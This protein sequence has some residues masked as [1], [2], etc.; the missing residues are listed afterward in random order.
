ME[1][2]HFDP[3]FKSTVDPHRSYENAINNLGIEI[4]EDVPESSG[5]NETLLNNEISLAMSSAEH[6]Q[7][8]QEIESLLL[9]PEAA[10]I[11]PPAHVKT[12]AS[13]ASDTSSTKNREIEDI[14]AKLEIQR[15]EASCS[16]LQPNKELSKP[17]AA[18]NNLPLEMLGSHCL[19]HTASKEI[20][21]NTAQMVT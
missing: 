5:T 9:T 4:N 15:N 13:L 11:L 3:E 6:V 12:W 10:P 17:K 1:Y 19:M 16:Y 14:V 2:T 8:V 20:N 18:D 7:A 21:Y